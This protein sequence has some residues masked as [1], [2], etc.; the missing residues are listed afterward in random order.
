MIHNLEEIPA[1]ASEA[2]EHAY[3]AA[4]ELSDALWAQA[5]PLDP[6][7]LPPPR[8]TTTPVVIRLD[9]AT[10]RR[11]KRLARRRHKAYPALL[12]ELITALL[13]AEDRKIG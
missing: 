7:E 12:S 9:E 11:A 6:S 4:H 10:L 3:W 8:V 1:F 13:A 2:E 5:Q